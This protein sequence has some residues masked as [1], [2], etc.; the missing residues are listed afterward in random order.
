[1]PAD[2]LLGELLDL[3][4]HL[5]PDELVETIAATVSRLPAHGFGVYVVDY[6][7]RTLVPL[8][9]SPGEPMDVNGTLAGR[10]YRL[11]EVLTER[12]GDD[13]VTVWVPIIDGSD[14][15]GAMRVTVP[16]LDDE[17]ER[18]LRQLASLVADMLVTKNQ[19]GDGME[20]TRRR[21]D[22]DLAAE[23]RWSLLPP[24]TFSHPQVALAGV[25]EPAYEIAGDCFDYA[26]NG[27]LVHVAILDA[28]GHGLEASRMANLAVGAYRNARRHGLDLAETFRTID[29]IVASQFG[30]E[31]FVTAQLGTLDI[32][33]GR[34]TWVN[35]GPP[36]PLLLRGGSAAELACE[37]RVPLGLG[38][39]P[40]VEAQIDLEPGDQLL[41]FTDG[42]TEA[43]SPDGD[44]FGRDQLA[45]LLVRAAGAGLLVAETV[46]RLCHAVVD[47]EGTQLRD[48]AT[49]FLL[50]WRGRQAD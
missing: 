50:E 7:Q 30:P 49:L 44:L 34:L 24:L 21:M 35:A 38:D 36:R 18:W 32:S 6:S 13:G 2:S 33:T 19:Y 8:Q 47:H 22:M 41:L 25:L 28:M 16:E 11:E 5:H 3:A 17:L 40:A 31:R 46:R 27:D 39:V 12:A 43:R 29:D 48:D 23:L 45:D 37:P 4:R 20:L 1:M 14:R 26:V 9:G 10:V 15:L 42:V